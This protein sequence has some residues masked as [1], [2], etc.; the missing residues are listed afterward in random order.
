MTRIARSS[1]ANFAVVARLSNLENAVEGAGDRP[2]RKA[3]AQPN[4]AADL[5]NPEIYLLQ[6]QKIR[7]CWF[8]IR[9]ENDAC[10][11]VGGTMRI[12]YTDYQN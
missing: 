8:D 12:K 9:T 6:T 5:E 7:A 10:I 4:V 2:Q 3:A 11:H 1:V